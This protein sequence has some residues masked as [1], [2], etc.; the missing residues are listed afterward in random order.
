VFASDS[1]ATNS[2]RI[3]IL[4][5]GKFFRL[6]NDLVIGSAGS[7]REIQIVKFGLSVPNWEH[8]ET[9]EHF[10][11][12]LANAIKSEL[13]DRLANKDDKDCESSFIV[14]YKNRLFSFAK[15]FQIVEYSNPFEAIG[16]GQ[17]YAIGGMEAM[18]QSGVSDPMV[19]AKKSVEI[20]IKYDPWTVGPVQVMQVNP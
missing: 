18:I 4:K 6:N 2:D 19:I 1:A 9:D 14:C 8:A 20:A 12:R 5:E 11:Y 13:V 7:V 17:Y 15:D 16:S 3:W 10:M